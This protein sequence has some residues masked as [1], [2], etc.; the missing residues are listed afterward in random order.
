M[1]RNAAGVPSIEDQ[2]TRVGP[3]AAPGAGMVSRRDVLV[4]MTGIACAWS[5]HAASEL[6]VAQVGPMTGPLGPNG[7][8]NYLGAKACFD[9]VNAHDGING[10]K[11]RFVREDDRYKAD[12]TLRLL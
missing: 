6:V 4:G 9:S 10:A 12:E 2:E 5:S 1:E 7:V 8:A 3:A 11:I